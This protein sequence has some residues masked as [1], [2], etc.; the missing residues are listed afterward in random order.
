M[1]DIGSFV[2]LILNL[3]YFLVAIFLAFY[4]PGSLLLKKLKL[5]IF[6]HFVL[7]L[8]L[9]IVLWGLQGFIF[10]F[11]QVRW[12]SYVYLIIFF[13]F[14][15]KQYLAK[16]NKIILPIQGIRKVDPLIIIMMVIGIAIHVSMLLL[17]GIR[18]KDGLYFCCGAI[19]DFLYHLRL[20]YEIIHRLPPYEPDMHGV[21]VHNYHYLGNIVVADLVRVFRLPLIFTQFQYMGVVVSSLLGLLAIVFSQITNLPK[22]IT[23][24]LI[25]FLYFGGDLIFV[26]IF[27]LGRGINLSMGPLENGAAFLNNPP[28]AFAVVAFFA[29]LCF[30]SL[31]IKKRDFYTGIFMAVLI[32]SLIGLKVYIG[33]FALSGFLLLGFYYFLQKKIKQIIPILLAIIISVVVYFP[34]NSNAGGLHFSGFWRFEEFIVQPALGLSRLE[35][36]RQVYFVHGSWLRVLQYDIIFLLL[37]MFSI[38]GT[39]LIGLLQTKKTLSYFHKEIH[40]VLFPGIIVSFLAGSFFW[41]HSGGSNSFNFLVSVYII[42][43]IYTAIACFYWIKKLNRK[44]QIFV[45]ILIILVNLPRIAFEEYKNVN[46]IAK[47]GGN[48]VINEDLQAMN[49]LKTHT[50]RSS[51]ILTGGP[52]YHPFIAERSMYLG[53]HGLLKSHD[54]DTSQRQLVLKSILQYQNPLLVQKLLHENNISYVYL[55]S[56]EATI[57]TQSAGILKSVFKNKNVHILK[58]L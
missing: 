18:L 43:S 46:I 37:F 48:L 15:I 21:L 1:Y 2:P 17:M 26:L 14:G 16:H 34:V 27:L 56:S 49:F 50:N 44:V 6:Q 3:P 45:T 47:K 41:Q 38:F 32:G 22:I 39:K 52:I 10:G 7:S 55:S 51:I 20:T 33:I 28:R 35:L 54:V 31:W 42:G 4:I 5:P 13:I 40:I 58:V 29:A 12:I 36:A 57:S 11:L 53:E 23:R 25:F 30:F 8:A 24:W 19:G 9:G